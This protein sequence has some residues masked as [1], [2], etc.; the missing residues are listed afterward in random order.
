MSDLDLLGGAPPSPRGGRS[1]LWGCGIVAFSFVLGG[2]LGTVLR[3]PLPLEVGLIIGF[4]TVFIGLSI[5][6]RREALEHRSALAHLAELR[7]RYPGPLLVYRARA[8]PHG[9]RWV[10]FA[11][12]IEGSWDLRVRCWSSSGPTDGRGRVDLPNVLQLSSPPQPPV[13]DGLPARLELSGVGDA[14]VVHANLASVDADHP[15]AQFLLELQ[16]A[17]EELTGQGVS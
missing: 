1:T 7:G 9:G 13:M 8:L 17:C 6:S 14:V 15:T 5:G 11:T 16:A 10:A 3:E 12:P 4:S 2:A